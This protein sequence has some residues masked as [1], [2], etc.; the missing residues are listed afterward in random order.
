MPNFEFII[1]V[2]M[3]TFTV[4]VSQLFGD[5]NAAGTI[6]DYFDHVSEYI[7][8]SSFDR[9]LTLDMCELW[10]DFIKYNLIAN[11]KYLWQWLRSNG[12]SLQL[13]ILLI[14]SNIKRKDY[15][16][17]IETMIDEIVKQKPYPQ[18]VAA[19]DT[20]N[21]NCGDS[22]DVADAWKKLRHIHLNHWN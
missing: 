20:R 18:F 8:S 16:S 6:S 7:G 5:K 13:L 22:V 19:E 1:V 12:K 14:N 4:N 3:D 10:R 17:I 9:N 15:T 11:T 21:V 2:V